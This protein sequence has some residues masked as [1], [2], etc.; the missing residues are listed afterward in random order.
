M[1]DEFIKFMESAKTNHLKQQKITM[2]KQK[3]WTRVRN[4]FRPDKNNGLNQKEI[5][6]LQKLKD[7]EEFKDTLFEPLQMYYLMVRKY[8]NTDVARWVAEFLNDEASEESVDEGFSEINNFVSLCSLQARKHDLYKAH[9]LIALLSPHRSSTDQN[10]HGLSNYSSYSLIP[11]QSPTKKEEAVKIEKKVEP[12]VEVKIETKETA[13]VEVVAE[14]VPTQSKMPK[15]FVAYSY[16]HPLAKGKLY[17]TKLFHDVWEL[18]PDSFTR[19]SAL[20]LLEQNNIGSGA[21]L[22]RIIKE[23][24]KDQFLIKPH[25]GYYEKTVSRLGS[26]IESESSIEVEQPVNYKI[27]EEKIKQPVRKLEVVNYQRNKSD[28][29]YSPEDWI[30]VDAAQIE[31]GLNKKYLIN[32]VNYHQLKTVGKTLVNGKWTCVVNYG[33]LK[34][35]CDYKEKVAERD[36]HQRDCQSC[37]HA[38]NAWNDN[39]NICRPC[40]SGA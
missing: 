6:V 10:K 36:G 39:V 11:Q 7:K 35:F 26:K 3:F 5:N 34:D 1:T 40:M 37:G 16:N 30:T 29:V 24:S 21:F 17:S 14:V 20:I 2:Q 32:L 38:F 28:V 15:S 22:H 8:G 19:Q 23:C 31:F 27:M 4:V 33:E 18:L 9:Y 12:S 25:S 13:P